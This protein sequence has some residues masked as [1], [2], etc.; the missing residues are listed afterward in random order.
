MDD[1]RS[2]LQSVRGRVQR[3]EAKGINEQNTKATL[4]EPILRCLGWN[5]EDL[6]EVQFEYRRKRNSNP[7]D[8]AL[9]VLR[10][11]K[12]FVEAKALGK[13]LGDSR[14]ASQIMGYAAEAGVKWVV[15]TDGDEYRIYNSHA[16]VPVESKLFRSVRISEGGED[17]ERTLG[18]LSK[19]RIGDAE[20]D[21]YWDA[22]HIDSQVAVALE[23]LFADE[24]DR[25]LVNVVKKKTGLSYPEVKASLK[26]AR[27][28]VDFPIAT[29]SLPQRGK[30][31]AR[32]TG[33]TTKSER[34]ARRRE[35]DT[36]VVP[37]QK[38]G[39]ERVFLG[40]NRWYAIRLNRRWIPQLKRIAAYQ[41]RPVSAVT[42][43]AEVARIEPFEDTG[44]FVVVFKGPA[45][46]IDPIPVSEGK[47][48]PQGPVLVK[49]DKLLSS[50]TLDQALGR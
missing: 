35:A 36:I 33:P 41:S 34:W 32:R 2:T 31:T 14:W 37:A 19:G 4:V 21:K 42:H 3:Y 12:L 50:K 17:L 44:K 47:Y 20:I 22:Y 25:P 26:R 7:V 8:Y 6:D 23:E 16:P 43:V 18:L 28:Q 29:T 5:L 39:F 11:P 9:F 30:K 40:E 45:Q 46:E 13:N 15:L 38:E 27:V 1:L 24:P 48:A 10:E 49:Y